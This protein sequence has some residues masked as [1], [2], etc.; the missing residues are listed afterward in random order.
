MT[1]EKAIKLL[2][3]LRCRTEARGAT[4]AE[5]M[6]AA[7]LSADIIERYQ[8]DDQPIDRQK[9]IEMGEG[10]NRSWMNLLAGG[11]RKRFQL[12]SAVII[13]CKGQYSK[14]RFTGPEHAVGVAC[15]LFRAIEVDMRKMASLECI[16]RDLYGA[17]K[18]RFRNAFMVSCACAIYERLAPI[19]VTDIVV[20]VDCKP[21]RRRKCKRKKRL[22]NSDVRKLMQARDAHFVGFKAGESIKL[23]TDVL[24][25]SKQLLLTHAGATS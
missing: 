6:Q 12:K 23:N 11:I 22:K 5:A 1:R 19:V 25:G 7:K 18:L 20:P 17:A 2:E 15:W 8:L 14:V 24:P 21:K 3:M 4:P 16:R 13:K 10:G 9:G